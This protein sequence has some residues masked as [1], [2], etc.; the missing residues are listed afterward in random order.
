M[1]KV[2][3]H[4]IHYLLGTHVFVVTESHY[5]Y[6]MKAQ[7]NIIIKLFKMGTTFMRAEELLRSTQV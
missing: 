4:V 1:Y 7:P 6:D 3:N 5:V 2:L